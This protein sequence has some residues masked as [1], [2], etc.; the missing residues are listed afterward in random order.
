[1]ATKTKAAP[2]AAAKKGN[3]TKA[4]AKKVTAEKA[5]VFVKHASAHDGG[6]GTPTV[7]LGDVEH[8]MSVQTLLSLRRDINDL[9][10][11]Y[12]H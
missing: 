8:T 9:A 5:P 11:G 1:M 7:V 10:A 3:V 6:D 2:K 12:V 4:A